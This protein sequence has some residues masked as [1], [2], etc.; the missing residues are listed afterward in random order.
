MKNFY[1]CIRFK[2]VCQVI[3]DVANSV[4]CNQG[5]NGKSCEMHTDLFGIGATS[6][7]RSDLQSG[8]SSFM[9]F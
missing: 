5:R 1:R 2:T 4:I 9:A 6:R 7:L 3:V 8:L